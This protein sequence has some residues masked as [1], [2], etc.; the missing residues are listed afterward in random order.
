M[1]GLDR[2]ARADGSLVIPRRAVPLTDR[3]IAL[4]M[5][6]GLRSGAVLPYELNV[7]IDALEDTATRLVSESG[8]GPGGTVT[9][10]SEDEL[11]TISQAADVVGISGRAIRYAIS[12]RQLFGTKPG[13]QWL[14][15][16]SDL[17]TYRFRKAG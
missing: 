4:G 9:L 1:A 8:R 5:T 15:R 16:A 3:L 7:L 6:A 13:S 2:F 17:D 10:D 11:L 12:N 14:I